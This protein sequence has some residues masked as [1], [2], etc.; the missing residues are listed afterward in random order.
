MNKVR[1]LIGDRPILSVTP[2]MSVLDVAR[3]MS[4]KRVGAVPVLEGKRPIGMFS[5]RDLMERVVL[6]GR[7]AADTT[8]ADVMTRDLVVAEADEN[9]LRC[10]KMM[11]DRPCRHL[12]IIAAGELIGVLSLRDLLHVQLDRKT[13]ELKWA[14]AYIRDVPPDHESSD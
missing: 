7:S 4:E 8:V 3:Y 11:Q 6:A 12:P 14:H 9:P 2:E 1:S 5:E 13:E 10:M